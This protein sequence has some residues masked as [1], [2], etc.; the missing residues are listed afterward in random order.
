MAKSEQTKAKL[1]IKMGEH[2]LSHGLNTASLRPLAEAAKT[3]DRM[4]IYHFGSKENLIG[5][6]LLHLA[7]E[8]QEKLDAALPAVRAKSNTMYLETVVA[9]LRREP[10]ARY[11]RVW[12]DIVSAAGHG[13]NDH[14]AI[15]KKMIDGYMQWLE[16]RLP[17]ENENPRATLALLFTIIE[18]AIVMDAVGQ[19]QLANQAIK[20]AFQ[21]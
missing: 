2:V 16:A 17:A 1:L 14:K 15:G 11:M 21:D 3:S 18:G 9:L 8:L 19:S 5:E 20:F 7:A 4:L 10:F 12:L 13:S 6:L